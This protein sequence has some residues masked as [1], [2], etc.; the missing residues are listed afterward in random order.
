M[1]KIQPGPRK[2]RTV[3]ESDAPPGTWEGRLR[4]WIAID[5]HNALGPGKV[6]LLEA[7]AV[8]KS[9]SA[10]AKRL[11]MSYRAA[12]RHL[13]IIEERTG[14]TV[15]EPRRGGPTGGG[16]DLTP[17]G[18]ALL[19]A[20]HNFHREVEEHMHSACRRHFAPWS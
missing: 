16:T 7:I 6:R 2:D 11:H 5:G 19:D 20:F 9:L 14:I 12:W 1:P 10:A 13:R 17:Q 3:V 8:H 15:V 18:Q 4:L